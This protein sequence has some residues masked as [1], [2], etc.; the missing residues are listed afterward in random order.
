MYLKFHKIK[1]LK[2]EKLLENFLLQRFKPTLDKLLEY[3]DQKTTLKE[4]IYKYDENVARRSH[5]IAIGNNILF[6]DW[7]IPFASILHH[8]DSISVYK[9]RN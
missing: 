5:R 3:E 4:I 9:F 1:Y 6:K 2:F 7:Y 8:G